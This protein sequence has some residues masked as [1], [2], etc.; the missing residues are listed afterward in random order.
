L[1]ISSG[2][3]VVGG[4]GVGGAPSAAIDKTCAQAGL[5]AIAS[6]GDSCVTSLPGCPFHAI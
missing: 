4:I 2:G 5:A 6:A 3:K 1:P